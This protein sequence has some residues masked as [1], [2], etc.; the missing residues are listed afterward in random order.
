MVQLTWG[1]RLVGKLF[2]FAP[3]F[4]IATMTSEQIEQSQSPS[5]ETNL[6]AQK[7]TNFI[8]G[9]AQAGVLVTERVFDGP[10]CNLALRIYQPQH[11]ANHPRPL[12][13]YY[14]GGGWVLGN[15]QSSDWLCST[16]ARDVDAVVVSVGYRLAPKHKFPAAIEDCLSALIWSV[17]NAG[18]LDADSTRLGVMGDS[19][20]ANLAAVI[21]LLA[22]ERGGPDIN[23]AALFYPVMDGS[24]STG[25]FQVNKDTIILSAA[26]MAAFYGH[27]LPDGTDPL[28]WRVSP[29]YAPDL[30]GFPSTIIIVAGHDPLHDEGVQFATKLAEAGVPVYLKEYPAMPHGFISFPYFSR[31]AKPATA[32]V[33]ASQRAVLHR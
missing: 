22:N 20:G 31:D 1:T 28:D 17:D 11:A 16:V 15:P 6:L 13:V 14:H 3:E 27:Y 18:S 26:D 19:A 8:I 24:M 4:S 2:E 30:T 23:H 29:L 9:T 33:T 21:C 5:P 10:A 25:S 32:E 12:I 7:F